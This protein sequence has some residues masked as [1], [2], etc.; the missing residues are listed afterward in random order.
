MTGGYDDASIFDLPGVPWDTY[1]TE[2]GIAI[3][4]TFWHNDFG[5]PH[6]HGCINLPPDAARWVYR[7][8]SPAVPPGE[9]VLLAPGSGTRV[10]IHQT[11]TT[12]SWREP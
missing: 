12:R 3:H 6:S 10:T 2:S 5:A 11:Q 1:I 9:K 7:W 8:T 4:G